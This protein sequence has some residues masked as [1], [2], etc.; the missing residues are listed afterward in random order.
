MFL[1]ITERR[2]RDVLIASS[3]RPLDSS[4]KI[5]YITHYLCI[6][7]DLISPNVLREILKTQL[8]HILTV[9]EN[10][11]V[12]FLKMSRKDVHRVS[13]LGR[14]QDVHFEPFRTI[15]FS[16]HY[17]QSYFT[18]CV[19]ETLK[20]QLFHGFTSLE[21]SQDVNLIIIL[22]I[23]LQGNFCIFMFY[24]SQFQVYIIHCRV[25]KSNTLKKS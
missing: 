21:H 6:I 17:F 24:I 3:G 15:V 25:K 13:F 10:R 7:F 18:K 23:F 12:D 19:S 20:S 14:L 16:L 11:P 4:L 22:K 9:L 2:P 8:L 1:K 5:Y